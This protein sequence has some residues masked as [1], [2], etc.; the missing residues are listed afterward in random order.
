MTI[1]EA[2]SSANTLTRDDKYKLIQELIADLARGEGLLE[3]EYPVWSQYDA[4][5]AAASLK[6]LLEMNKPKAGTAAL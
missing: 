5:E 6:N 2:Y 3:S 4:H 1:A